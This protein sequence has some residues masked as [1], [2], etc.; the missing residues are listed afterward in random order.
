MPSK[1]KARSQ[2]RKAKKE[3]KQAAMSSNCGNGF[4]AGGSSCTH[5]KLPENRTLES[6]KDACALFQDFDGKFEAYIKRICTGMDEK[7]VT[8]YWQL[9]RPLLFWG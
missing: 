4:C 9:M 3:A 2:A 6:F 5:I 8:T 1:K 7:L